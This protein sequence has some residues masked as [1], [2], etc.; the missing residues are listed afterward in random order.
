MWLCT[1]SWLTPIHVA[2]SEA[3]PKTFGRDG[4]NLQS[5]RRNILENGP[6]V[7][8]ALAK[9]RRAADHAMQERLQAVTDKNFQALS[10]H[11]HDYFIL[12][13]YIWPN[14]NTANGLPCVL[15]DG[16]NSP[17]NENF[18]TVGWGICVKKLR[19]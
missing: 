18:E 12:S 9:I 14:P 8:T 5:I 1:A 15:R 17:E 7:A 6:A 13:T 16:E 4:R 2:K 3:A 19:F 10:R 11:E